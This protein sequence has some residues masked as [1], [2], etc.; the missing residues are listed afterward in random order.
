MYIT[1]IIV[2]IMY[3]ILFNTYGAFTIPQLCGNCIVNSSTLFN[4]AQHDFTAVQRIFSESDHQYNEI[5]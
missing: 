1:I 2:N 3:V 5:T 4:V